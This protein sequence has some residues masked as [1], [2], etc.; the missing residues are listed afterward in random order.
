MRPDFDK[1]RYQSLIERATFN[2]EFWRGTYQ[3]LSPSRLAMTAVG[4]PTWGKVNGL[5]CLKQRASGDRVQS[6]VV[7]SVVD[8]ATSSYWVESIWSP[9]TAVTSYALYQFNGGGWTAYSD[10]A[11]RTVA[12]GSLTAAG[13]LARYCF[14]AAGSTP[15][16]RPTHVVLWIDVVGLS[17][18]AWING[19]PHAVT[20]VNAAPPVACASTKLLVSA[21]GGG[22]LQTL[23]SRVWQGT[24]SNE[25]VAALYG[26]ASV[27]TGG[28]C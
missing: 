12:I 9:H 18:R 20:F 28:E 26:A 16:N 2:C 22:S 13:A 11:N 4:T 1:A 21:Q 25:D 27:L 15:L 23:L 7:P 24:P 17:G 8:T 5:P 19:I 10:G 6:G 3:D 14:P